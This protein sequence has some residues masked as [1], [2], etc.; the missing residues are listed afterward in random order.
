[1]K[2][3]RPKKFTANNKPVIIS[4]NTYDNIKEYTCTNCQRIIHTRKSQGN[5]TCPHCLFD[6]PVEKV[7][8]HSKLETP[9]RNTE[10]LISTTPLPGQK[11]VAIKKNI[12]LQWGAKALSQRGTIKFTSYSEG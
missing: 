4:D 10:T 9:H 8:R 12:D 3:Y 1:M 2:K 11:D 5:L 7:R 6:F